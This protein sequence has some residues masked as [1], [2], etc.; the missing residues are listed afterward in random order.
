MVESE[1]AK[2]AGGCACGEVRLGF[3][4]PIIAMLA[5]HCRSCQY[6][7]GG[8]PA[9]L[10]NVQ[11]NQFRVTRGH[12]REHLTLS[13]AGNAVTRV[14]CGTCG[15]QLYSWSEGTPEVCSIKVGCLDAPPAFK[16]KMHLWVSEAPGWHPLRRLARR[17]SRNR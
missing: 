14:F 1:K 4:E 10:V 11:R 3:Y 17:F 12:P 7:S 9:Y 16:P 15:T 13:E 8:G 6:A 2:Y 5:C